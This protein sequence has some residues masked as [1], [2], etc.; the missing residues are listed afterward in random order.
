MKEFERDILYNYLSELIIKGKDLPI[1][2]EVVY[3]TFKGNEYIDWTF[4]GLLKYIYDLE[5]KNT[6]YEIL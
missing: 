1:K 2:D 6:N 5:D 4:K 3:S